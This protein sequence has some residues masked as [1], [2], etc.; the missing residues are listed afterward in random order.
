L[1]KVC[2]RRAKK[3]PTLIIENVKDSLV[4][5]TI[6]NNNPDKELTISRIYLRHKSEKEQKSVGWT[7]EWQPRENLGKYVIDRKSESTYL[8]QDL[9]TLRI[10]KLSS[11]SFIFTIDLGDQNKCLEWNEN[12]MLIV[13]YIG[14]NELSMLVSDLKNRSTV[15][16]K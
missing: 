15:Y 6:N 13:E 5:F 16:E 2:P 12:A 9:S 11:A 3:K 4:L 8:T 14:R 1:V 10:K 7:L